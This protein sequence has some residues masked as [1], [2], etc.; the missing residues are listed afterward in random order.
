VLT[1]PA[2]FL[3]KKEPSL[4]INDAATTT[5]TKWKHCEFLT[6]ATC[7]ISFTAPLHHGKSAK[8]N[9]MSLWS[10]HFQRTSLYYSYAYS[11][12]MYDVKS[13]VLFEKR[14]E[15]KLF[16]S[17]F[18]L[19]KTS[20]LRL[21]EMLV[22]PNTIATIRKWSSPTEDWDCPDHSTAAFFIRPLFFPHS[23]T[24][25]DVSYFLR[26]STDNDNG[27]ASTA[28]SLLL[29]VFQVTTT[30]SLQVWT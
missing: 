1:L 17:T 9:L 28:P 24:A 20:M 21:L 15:T 10:Y 26:P 18:G 25:D 6:T 5:T 12:L 11:L 4:S 7:A 22:T 23:G 14:K 30:R 19:S 16:S 2:S 29:H 27:P 3:I 13:N 8:Y